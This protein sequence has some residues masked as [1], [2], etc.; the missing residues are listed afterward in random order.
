MVPLRPIFLR[1]FQAQRQVIRQIA[2]KGSCVIIGRCADYILKDY[3]GC[4][5][6]FIRS[7]PDQ[8]RQCIRRF[9][10]VSV[11]SQLLS[12]LSGI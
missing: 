10:A 11:I 12:L 2:R 6:I 7:D 5:R 1:L 4:L 3:P 8:R 9:L